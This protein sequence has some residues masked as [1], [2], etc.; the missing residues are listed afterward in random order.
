MNSKIILQSDEPIVCPKCAHPFSL[1]EGI[2]RQAIDRHAE[3]FEAQ[4]REGRAEL[5]AHLEQEARRHA[6]Q[7]TA[8]QIAKLQD[9][10]ASAKRAEREAQQT[11]EQVR[12]AA[13][14]KAIADMAQERAAL[15]EDLA[16][17]DKALGELRAQELELRR[18]GQALVEQ[19]RNLEL[20]LQ[21]RL[22]DERT[23]ISAAAAQREAE[24]YSMMEAEWRKKIEDAQRA[25]EDLRRKLEQGSQQLQG[26]VL[27]LEV[28]QSLATSFFHDTI[29]EVKKGQ[30]G[31][32]VI[33]TVRTAMGQVAGIIIW[34]AKR[35]EN[36][37]DKWLEKLKDDQQE[38]KAD[39]AVLV[40]TAM[41]KGLTGAF[42][43]VGDVWVISR[44]V[45]KPMAET[46]RVILLETAKLKA[47]NVGKAEK[48]ELLYSYLASPTFSQRMRSVFDTFTTMQADLDSERRALTKIWAKRQAQIDRATKSMSTVV[49][50]LQGIAQDSLPDLQQLESLEH[51]AGGS[52]DALPVD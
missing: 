28:E 19:Q 18:K 43:R 12:K 47:A 32:D 25:N 49:G 33:Q 45:L 40:T 15:L 14:E 16:A 13:Q 3:E 29:D 22:D 51:I 44:Q 5:A 38:A 50:E 1:G 2:S 17:K 37:S 8:E 23:K 21:R 34:E 24:R 36:W 39:I 42:G 31:A 46:L 10:V 4:I 48:I 7:A 11:I 6:L 35:A 20:E 26:E 41:P 30:R 9:Q 52:M 27:E